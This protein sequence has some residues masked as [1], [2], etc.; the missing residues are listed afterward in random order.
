MDRKELLEENGGCSPMVG[1]G[2]AVP[3]CLLPIVGV[4]ATL[5]ALLIAVVF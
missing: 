5:S 2:C 1:C 4:V 3:G